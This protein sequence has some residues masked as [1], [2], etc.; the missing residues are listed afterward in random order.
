MVKKMKEK[1]FLRKKGIKRKAFFT[2]DVKQKRI[3][4]VAITFVITS[5]DTNSPILPSSFL[6]LLE[7]KLSIVPIFVPQLDGNRPL[8][9]LILLDPNNTI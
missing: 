2:K 9:H 8:V 5:L 6:C 3:L 1:T 7:I 4:V